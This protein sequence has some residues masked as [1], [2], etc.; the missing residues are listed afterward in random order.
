[1]D[2]LNY[3]GQIDFKSK[4]KIENEALGLNTVL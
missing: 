4:T 3:N 1:M 2:N